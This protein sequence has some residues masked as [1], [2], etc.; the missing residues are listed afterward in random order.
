MKHLLALAVAFALT[1]VSVL[2][3][4]GAITGRVVD[5]HTG[6]PISGVPVFI[7][8]LPVNEGDKPVGAMRTDNKG[9]FADVSLENGQYLVA[10]RVGSRS[11]G[12]TVDDIFAGF[13]THIVVEVGHG[14]TACEGPHTASALVNPALTADEYII[15]NGGPR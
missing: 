4:E 7:Y 10:T 13:V 6:K 11:S 1:T 3:A 8:R 9:G 2:A 5:L 14:E 12:C 15:T